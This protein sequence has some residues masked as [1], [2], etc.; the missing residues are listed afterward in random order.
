[1]H[2]PGWSGTFGWDGLQDRGEAVLLLWRG[3]E[4]T[5]CS[6]VALEFLLASF[7]EA[8]WV[9]LVELLIPASGR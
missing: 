8:G 5:V 2:L 9:L 4:R 3:L 6:G 7:G 1:M